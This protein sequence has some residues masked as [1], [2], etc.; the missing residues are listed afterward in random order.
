MPL[1]ACWGQEHISVDS[2]PG[3]VLCSQMHT[4]DSQSVHLY[5]SFYLFYPSVSFFPSLIHLPALSC[6]FKPPFQFR[7]PFCLFIKLPLLL[8]M[9]ICSHSSLPR[10]FPPILYFALR[11][12]VLVQYLMAVRILVWAGWVKGQTHRN[13]KLKRLLSLHHIELSD[14]EPSHLSTLKAHLH[15][16]I[17]HKAYSHPLLWTLVTHSEANETLDVKNSAATCFTFTKQCFCLIY[18]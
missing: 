10:S 9:S 2:G 15:M 17:I 7:F 5:V 6:T 16:F 3:N 1:G 8:R 11:C 13:R 18:L 12:R 14:Q 4:T